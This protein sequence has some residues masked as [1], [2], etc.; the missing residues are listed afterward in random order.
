MPEPPERAGYVH[1]L[2]PRSRSAYWSIPIP[3]HLLRTA[4]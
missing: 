3:N 1:P 4:W 2:E